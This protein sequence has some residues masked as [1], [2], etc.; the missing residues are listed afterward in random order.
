M[1][2]VELR[3]F[4]HNSNRF[5]LTE[6]ELH[7]TIIE[8]WARGDW[9]EFGER[10]WSPHQATLTVIEGPELPLN[11]ISLGRGWRNATRRGRDVTNE[12]LAA[13]ARRQPTP[14]PSGDSQP[15]GDRAQATVADALGRS[16]P[17]QLARELLALLGDDPTSLLRAWQLALERHPDRTPSQC[18]A[19]AEDFL[20]G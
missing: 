4:P 6:R 11:D 10:K 2:H 17:E 9:I 19:L 5:N 7:D 16:D 15:N 18:L 1:Y 12:L 13:A 14:A 8:A 20:R 3:Q